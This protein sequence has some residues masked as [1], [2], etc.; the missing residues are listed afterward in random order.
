MSEDNKLMTM[1]DYNEAAR[2]DTIER[3]H[4][5][6]KDY[7]KH[8][9]RYIRLKVVARKGKKPNY[10]YYY[11]V[12]LFSKDWMPASMIAVM[13]ECKH[14]GM[15][16]R[17]ARK[18]LQNAE[19]IYNIF[20]GWEDDETKEK[21]KVQ[22][23]IESWF[24]YPRVTSGL[25]MQERNLLKN[26][27]LGRG[28]TVIIPICNIIIE[29][30]KKTMTPASS[31]LTDGMDY[32][33]ELDD[34]SI[35]TSQAIQNR[36]ISYFYLKGLRFQTIGKK[37]FIRIVKGQKETIQRI[38]AYGEIDLREKCKHLTPLIV[39]YQGKK[40]VNRRSKGEAPH[41]RL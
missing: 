13:E 24:E 11:Q 16:S 2:Q 3:M 21:L 28:K 23:P 4:Y 14:K 36:C 22:F 29:E 40:V 31:I 12:S 20:E 30:G 26:N 32:P 6:M 9:L 35:E 33:V 5:Q 17:E 38:V 27:Q 10:K 1:K 37:K 41:H 19:D 8:P 39:K 25:I 18:I 34:G 15:T 7:Q